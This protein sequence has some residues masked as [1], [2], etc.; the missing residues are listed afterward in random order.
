[1]TAKD[2][3]PAS[4]CTSRNDP[5]TLL[6]FRAVLVM[7]VR[8]PEW[9]EQA[10][11]PLRN[12]ASVEVTDED[13]DHVDACVDEDVFEHDAFIVARVATIYA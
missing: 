5:P 9:K 12:I 3:C 10:I 4:A 6:I 1:M 2:E 13:A 8:L 7:N 11:C